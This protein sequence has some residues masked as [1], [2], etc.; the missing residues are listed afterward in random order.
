M[1]IKKRAVEY[2]YD[3]KTYEGLL[4]VDAAAS[5]KRPAVVI[6]HAWAGR[7]DMENAFA[8]KV[9]AMGYAAFALDL[10]GKGVTGS[11][12]EEN[13]KLMTPFVED[14]AML[15]ARMKNVVDVVRGL[16]EVDAK[17]V[18]A[19]GF[20]FGGL[21]VLDLARAGAD[22]NG[23]AS[24]HGL[25]TPP[26]NTAG[27]KITSKVLALHGWND[28]MVPPDAVTALAKEL[29][30][31]GADWQIHAYGGVMHAFTNKAANDPSFGTVY[32]A[33][34]D[35]RSWMAA[36]DFLKECFA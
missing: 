11:S 15:Q 8:E 19:I 5:G 28:P 3:G 7:T 35:R 2:D 25:F 4:A 9:A 29:T 20:C 34:A 32:D 33:R 27:K 6:S 22:V 21:C 14:R 1:A 17:K 13:Q 23:V 16:D 12:T 24:F 36:E 10:Y 18:A 30:D 26:G 31:A